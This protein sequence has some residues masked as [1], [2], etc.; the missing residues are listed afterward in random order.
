MNT[1]IDRFQQRLMR[2]MEA[3]L[4]H[5]EP[6]HTLLEGMRQ[7]LSPPDDP[8]RAD[9][10]IDLAVTLSLRDATTAAPVVYETDLTAGGH[11]G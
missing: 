2:A 1:E 4:A 3:R 5:G 6:A 10:D 11:C 9:V 8:A 7:R